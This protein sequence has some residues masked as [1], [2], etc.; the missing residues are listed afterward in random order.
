[1]NKTLTVNLSGQVFN[2]D[3]DAYTVLDKY[4]TS[5]SKHFSK[6]GEQEVMNDIESRIAELFIEKMPAGNNVVTRS[7]VDEVVAIMGKLDEIDD[8]TEQP[9]AGSEF[10][11]KADEALRAADKVINEKMQK[12]LY[13]NI[14]DQVVAGV[15]SGVAKWI[16][17]GAVL[18]RIL[19]AVLCLFYG[20]PLIVYI[21]MWFAVPEARTPAQKLEMN[22]EP[23]NAQTLGAFSSDNSGKSSGSSNGSGCLKFLLIAAAVFFV[24]FLGASFLRLVTHFFHLP[25]FIFG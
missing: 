7:M 23:V 22:G 20:L 2:I 10:R 11:A 24:L 16:G 6:K 9:S 21:I 18:V 4:I 3:E 1:M 19:W 8:E 17:C 25:F 14:D 13:R 5:L 15:C 12:K